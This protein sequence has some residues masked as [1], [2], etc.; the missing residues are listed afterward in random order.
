MA[1]I[2]TNVAFKEYNQGQ[3]LVLPPSLSELIGEND[4]VRVVNEV[5]ERMNITELIN[6]YSGGGT[7]AYHPKM[8]LKVLLYAYSVKIYTGRKIARALGQDIH[9]MWLSAMGRPD[10]RTINNFRSGKAKEVI[11]KLFKSMLEFLMEQNYIKLENYF[12]DGSSFVADA[13]KNKMAWKKNA[14]R[15]KALAEQ[16]CT[17]LFLKIDELN[18]TDNK[19]YGNNDLAENG[20]ATSIT[21]EDISKQVE[22]LDEC[23]KTATAD[24]KKRKAE[25]LKK[26]LECEEK[27]I[28]KYKD[29]IEI[30]GTRSGYSTTDN[31][32]SA[33]RMKNKVEVL[34]A[35]N[36]LA[37]CE[38]QFITGVSI[39]QNSNDAACFSQHMEQIAKQQ[40]SKPQCII[41][42]SIFGTEQ[43]CELLEKEGIKNL[44]KFPTFHT[45]DTKA[46]K[47]N[48]YLKQNFKYDVQ[49]DTYLCPNNQLLVYS[50]DTQFTHPKSGYVSNLKEYECKSCQGCPLYQDC[51]KSTDGANRKIQ[52]N[53]KLEQYKNQARENLKSKQG[54]ILRKQ[55]SIEIESC[56][57]DIKHNMGFRRMHLRGLKGAKTEITLIAMAHNMKK[58]YLKRSKR[59][60]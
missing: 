48:P 6:L 24:T 10:F 13:N 11:E 36:V 57:G 9:F 2:K 3:L 54:K 8:L 14:E 60:A 42:D 28:K 37:G 58:V 45:E 30:S 35:Y 23:I 40:P 38:D 5:V 50:R 26:K 49:A 33:M 17:E 4:L 18:E 53:Q 21:K 20:T 52:V 43:N 27:K 12:C 55:R 34:P 41:A 39:H 32:A 51:C 25:S 56:F 22:K 7:T 19:Q 1:K 47:E 16:K 29:Q 44:M 31:D 59:A 15:Y 46:Y